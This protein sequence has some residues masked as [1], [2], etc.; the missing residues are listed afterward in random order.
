MISALTGKVGSGKS[1]KFVS[2]SAEHFAKGGAVCANIHFDLDAVAKYCWKRGHRFRD[3][4]FKFLPMAED[5]CFHRHMMQARGND[6]LKVLVGIDEAHLF[7]PAA[8][9]RNLRVEFLSVESFVSQ[10]RR[11][12]CDIVLITQ[13][14]DNIWTQLRKQALFEIRCRDFRVIQLPLFGDALGSFMGL[15][16]TRFDTA[17]NTPLDKGKTKLSKEIFGLYSTMQPYNEEMAELMRTMPVFEG[18]VDKVGW[19]EKIFR[20][21]KPMLA[22][23]APSAIEPE[24]VSQS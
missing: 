2:D 21:P 16:W 20:R 9:Y 6:N 3:K 14:W 1:L 11:V 17:A 23:N 24:N 22:E 5:P 10:S 8:E 4:Q 12:N 19:L 15:S 7:F 13:A 18:G